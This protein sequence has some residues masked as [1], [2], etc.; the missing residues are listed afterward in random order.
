MNELKKVK[1]TVLRIS[2][3]LDLQKKYENEDLIKHNLVNSFIE[4]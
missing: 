1:I 3:Y 2:N 4:V